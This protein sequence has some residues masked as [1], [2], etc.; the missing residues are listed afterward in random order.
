M[1]KPPWFL[2]AAACL[3]FVFGA[4][5]AYA[6][7]KGNIQDINTAIIQTQSDKEYIF[8]LEIAQTPREQKTGLMHRKHMEQD[9]GMLFIFPKEAPQ[10]FWMKNTYMPLDIYYIN[11]AGRIDQIYRMTEPFSTKPLPSR[12]PA[13]AVLEI[14]G[15]LSDKLGIKEG[16]TIKHPFFHHKDTQ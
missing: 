11:G 13:L 6:A 2:T 8:T 16:D 12:N 1:L 15:G 14:N 3:I 9:A 7:N 4:F 10:A 5:Y